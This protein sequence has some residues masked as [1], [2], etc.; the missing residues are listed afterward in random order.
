MTGAEA[1]HALLASLVGAE[2]LEA[3]GMLKTPARMAKALGELTEGYSHQVSDILTTTFDA[4]GYDQVI[5]VRDIP[6]SSLCEHHV[7]PFMGKVSVAYLPKNRIVGLSKI[8]R[9]VKAF[10]RR[11]QV[12]E[13]LT[14]QIA[15]AIMEHLDPQGVA[16]V[17]TGHHTCMSLRGAEATGEMVTSSMLGVFRDEPETRAEVL[18]LLKGKP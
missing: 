3:E 17:V 6:F 15:N 16:V 14:S 2:A 8:P 18:S 7:L 1:A 5:V 11:L 12:Q 10:A 9:L 4:E 13:R